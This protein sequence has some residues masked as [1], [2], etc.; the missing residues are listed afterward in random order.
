MAYTKNLHVY[1]KQSP[2][3]YLRPITN[4]NPD[5]CRSHAAS[6]LQIT[7][8]TAFRTSRHFNEHNSL[9]GPSLL[10]TNL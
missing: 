2:L 10:I 7:H 6:E 1:L 5:L 4:S 3:S 9:G 8:I